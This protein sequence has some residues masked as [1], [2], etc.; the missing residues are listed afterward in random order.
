MGV[1]FAATHLRLDQRVAIKVL[2][3]ENGPE[4]RMRQRFEREARA[5]S[6]IRGEHAAR[7][8][9][10]GVLE[11]GIPYT[12][13][14]FLEG[15]DL[16]KALRRVGAFPVAE[17]V[18][19]VLQ[20]CEALAEAH[21]AGIVHRDLKPSNIFLARRAD[22]S[23]TVKLLDFGISKVPKHSES[24][25]ITN[26][27]AILGSPRY[28]PP[29]Q[30]RSAHDVDVR[31]DVW[32]LGATLFELLTGQPA[33]HA[34]TLPELCARILEGPTPDL[35]ST[36]SKAPPGLGNAIRRCLQRAP[37]ERFAS[38]AEL[39]AALAP[40]GPPDGYVSVERAA[41]ILRGASRLGT[42]PA[43]AMSSDAEVQRLQDAATVKPDHG[44]GWPPAPLSEH[45]PG[46]LQAD[47]TVEAIV[48]SGEHTRPSA[49]ST[50]PSAAVLASRTVVGLVAM[51]WGTAALFVGRAMLAPG[52]A[53]SKTDVDSAIARSAYTAGVPASREQ[54]PGVAP[55]PSGQLEVPPSVESASPPSPPFADRQA[56]SPVLAPPSAGPVIPRV[57]PPPLVPSAGVRATA[58][59]PPS[60]ASFHAR[61]SVPSDSVG[62][63]SPLDTAGFG[64]RR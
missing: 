2:V 7:V 30:I 57:H 44:D 20:A 17:S 39:A 49:R 51:I 10:V 22:G 32:S 29:E 46:T 6:K 52:P 60:V 43:E 33:F 53:V 26:E 50:K 27:S 5:A 63:P 48:S 14:E 34:A 1:V 19:Y 35:E 4:P 28:M 59:G 24:G 15:E 12:V 41:R 31:G 58:A 21:A 47:K 37:A 38:V 62:A 23:S 11:S 18:A 3:E 25:A 8:L 55:L 64:D 40:F 45:A 16:A 36:I 56:S 42:R 61:E 9:D 54:I 13:M